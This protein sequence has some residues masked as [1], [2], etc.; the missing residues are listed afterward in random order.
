MHPSSCNPVELARRL[1]AIPSVN[2]RDCADP[3]VGGEARFAA[4]VADFL[5]ARG[6]EVSTP[7]CIP[8]R[9]NVVA[10]IGASSPARTLMIEGHLDTVSVEGMV[11][12]PFGGEIRDGRIY[13]RGACDMKGGWAA[14]LAALDQ[15]VLA[16]F[17]ASPNRLLIVGAIDEERGTLGARWLAS[18]GVRADEAI[19]LEPT[20]L[21]L[22]LAH[23]NPCWLHIEVT[24]VA[25]HGADPARGINAI[26][27]MMAL[28]TGLKSIVRRLTEAQDHPLLGRATLNIGRL[29]GGHG[30]NIIPDRCS[31][32]VDIRLLPSQTAQDLLIPLR[33][34]IDCLAD[35]GWL[36]SASVEISSTGTGFQTDPKGSLAERLRR[37]GAAEGRRPADLGSPWFSDAG[38][39]SAVCGQV[40]VFGPGSIRQAH[41]ADEWI[42]IAEL[43]AGSRMLKHVLLDFSRER[44]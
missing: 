5:L 32:D 14:A 35:S 41:T 10:S 1:I 2:P 33:Q 24:G 8:D 23:K 4:E 18:E 17:R 36:K 26:E 11:V 34:R 37:A 15:E 29:Q 31:A 40:L 13:G 16:A 27:G 9:P 42:D 12:P 7:S 44:V 38:A 28:L 39:F 20:S 3:S 43:E 30:T 22:V 19:V 6:F 21:D 25:G